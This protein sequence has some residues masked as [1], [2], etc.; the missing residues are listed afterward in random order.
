MA[1][2]VFHILSSVYC[3]QMGGLSTFDVSS[4]GGRGTHRDLII[5]S[6]TAGWR[7]DLHRETLARGD[8]QRASLAAVLHKF[9]NSRGR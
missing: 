8:N 5:L 7:R 3:G 9:L 2:Q 4:S 1:S 6:L